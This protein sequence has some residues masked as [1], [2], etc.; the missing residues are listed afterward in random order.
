[1][2]PLPSASARANSPTGAPPT[3]R[4]QTSTSAPS[5][6]PLL[7]KSPGA[8]SDSNPEYARLRRLAN[9]YVVTPATVVTDVGLAPLSATAM[10]SPGAIRGEPPVIVME[11][12]GLGL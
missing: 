9:A 7:L 8:P 11:F 6:Y 5:A 10:R 3:P 4:C 12:V 1:M 2:T